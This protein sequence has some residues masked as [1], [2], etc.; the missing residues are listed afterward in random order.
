MFGKN[1]CFESF[2]KFPE[3]RLIWS[4]QVELSNL[5]LVAILEIDSAANYFLRVLRVQRPGF[6]IQHLRPEY[7]NSGMLFGK[8]IWD[9][10]P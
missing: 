3:E 8:A 10:L 2:R 7:R 5:P 4:Y 9:K 1:H 6:K